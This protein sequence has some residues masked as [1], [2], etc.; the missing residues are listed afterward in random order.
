MY[1]QL[2]QLLV[3]LQIKMIPSKGMCNSEIMKS[4][5]GEELDYSNWTKL[6]NF[7]DW[8]ASLVD[9]RGGPFTS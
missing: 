9:C 1:I 4:L 3:S 5:Y 6:G 2:I 7:H 8:K